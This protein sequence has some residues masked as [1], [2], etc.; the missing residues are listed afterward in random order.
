VSIQNNIQRT[1]IV[2][3]CNMSAPNLVVDDNS[4]AEDDEY[5]NP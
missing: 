4:G 3:G 1:T 2:K 5:D